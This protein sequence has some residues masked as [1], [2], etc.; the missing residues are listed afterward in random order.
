M[1]RKKKRVKEEVK[2]VGQPMEIT[3]GVCPICPGESITTMIYKMQDGA[4]KETTH[5]YH[6]VCGVIWLMDEQKKAVDT[7]GKDY[8][9][10]LLKDKEKYKDNAIYP[11]RVY[12]PIIEECTYGRKMLDVGFC[13][14]YL[15]MEMAAR[16]WVAYGIDVCA[17][18]STP[19][20]IKDDYET[21][22]FPEVEKYDLI[23]MGN[24]LENFTDPLMTLH[25][26]AD[27]LQPNGLLYI[28]TADTSFVYHN[29]SSGFTHWDRSN[30]IL[31]SQIKLKTVLESLGFDVILQRKNHDK[32]FTE[33]Q[34]MHLIA[35]KKYY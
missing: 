12:A 1:S 5:W 28:S 3:A 16:G 17:E 8:V 34:T 18:E 20:I 4:T 35:Q 19:R 30:Y 32:R 31:W 11:A 7:Y 10:K 13:S 29:G 21:F 22:N 6:C 24:V 15:M 9:A 14:P 26:T 27:L 33:N 2:E 25:K 23:W